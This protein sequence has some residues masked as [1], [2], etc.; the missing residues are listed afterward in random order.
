[1][2]D[3]FKEKIKAAEQ[4]ISE[5]NTLIYHWRKQ[6]DLKRESKESSQV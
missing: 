3:N 6:N 1:M 5:L 4:R 2:N